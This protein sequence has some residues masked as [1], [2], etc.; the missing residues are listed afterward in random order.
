M[1]PFR[2]SH[3]RVR[4]GTVRAAA[5]IASAATLAALATAC[6]NDTA[7]AWGYPD[8]RATLGSFSRALDAPCDESAPATCVDELDRLGTLADVAHGEVLDHRLLG[9]G[10][11]EALHALDRA[12]ALRAAAAAQA[13]ARRDP[14][15][16][17]FRRAV[18]AER[19]AYERL[20][21]VLEGVRTAPP[22]GEGTE[23]V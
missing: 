2:I 6:R 12:R 23:P 17:P 7:P 22:P 11:V 5:S 16:P 8:L 13:R 19:R 18:A 20:L 10:Y 1:T 21:A 4:A 9:P 15:H 3:R 14:H